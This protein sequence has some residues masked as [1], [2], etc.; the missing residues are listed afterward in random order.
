MNDETKKPENTAIDSNTLLGFFIP[1]IKTFDGELILDWDEKV[2]WTED[3]DDLDPLNV[4]WFWI[5]IEVVK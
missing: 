5:R 4:N 3:K 1:A 2:D